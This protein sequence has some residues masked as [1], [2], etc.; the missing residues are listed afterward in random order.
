MNSLVLGNIDSFYY[1]IFS[2]MLYKIY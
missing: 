1:Q 2:Y